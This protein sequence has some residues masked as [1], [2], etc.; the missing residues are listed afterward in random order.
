MREYTEWSAK[1]PLHFLDLIY[2]VRNLIFETSYIGKVNIH[3]YEYK[4]DV[5]RVH[6]IFLEIRLLNLRMLSVK[7]LA[8]IDKFLRSTTSTYEF[9]IIGIL[10]FGAWQSILT[11]RKSKVGNAQQVVQIELQPFGIISG[12]TSRSKS[13]RFEQCI[14][15]AIRDD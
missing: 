7:S 14:H 15:S 11:R 5:R 10:L 4:E 8:N 6:E 2:Y 1:I 13:N 3:I 12:R 9:H